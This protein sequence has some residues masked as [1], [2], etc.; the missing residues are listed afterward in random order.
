MIQAYRAH[1]AERQ[2]QGIPALE[3]WETLLGRKPL[4]V[5]FHEDNE[6]CLQ[7]CR[8]GKYPTMR[9]VSRTQK[10]DIN[11]LHDQWNKTYD[12]WSC[13]T[14]LMCA[15]IFTK[16][17]LTKDRLEWV[18]VRR[19][20]GHFTP[21]EFKSFSTPPAPPVSSKGGVLKGLKT[22]LTVKMKM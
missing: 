17:F 3:L 21:A 10:I 7:I 8:S 6:A 13:H 5:Q 11:F 2:A 4:K 18:R 14:K 1:E 9:H 12:G 22:V 20:I 16:P 19:L 15:D